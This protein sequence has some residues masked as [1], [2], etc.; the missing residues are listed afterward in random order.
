MM[1]APILD[2]DD[3]VIQQISDMLPLRDGQQSQAQSAIG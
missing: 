2:M 3:A 1:L